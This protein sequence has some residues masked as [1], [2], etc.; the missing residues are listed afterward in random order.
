MIYRPEIDGL[1]ALAVIPVILFHAGFQI[2]S[3]GFIGVDVFF[4]ISGYLITTILIDDIEHNRFSFKTF[5]LRRARRLLPALTL[6]MI[7]CIPVAMALM[8]PRQLDQFA[9]GLIAVGI[10]ASNILIWQES[11]YFDTASEEKPLL[12]TWSLGIEEQYYILF[13]IFLFLFWRFGKNR[14]FWLIVIMAAFS[15]MLSEW[16]A[17]YKPSA[18]FYLLPTRAWELFAGSMTAIVA[19]DRKFQRNDYLSIIGLI[20]IIL[21][22]FIYDSQDLLPGLLTLVPVA[23][24]ILVIL[25]S[26]EGTYVAKFLSIKPL[27]FIGL[28]S[29]SAYL[30]HQPLFAFSRLGTYLPLSHLQII[31]LIFITFILAYLSYKFVETPF[32]RG[33]I[34]LKFTIIPLFVVLCAAAVPHGVY[35]DWLYSKEQVN[36]FES[37]TQ[38]TPDQN[39]CHLNS[40]IISQED[41]IFGESSASPNVAVIGDSHA[42]TFAYVLGES[43]QKQNKSLLFN[44]Y[45]HCPPILGVSHLGY[46]SNCNG[47]YEQAINKAINNEELDTI[48]LVARW[49][50]YYHGTYFKNPELGQEK[51]ADPRVGGVNETEVQRKDNYLKKL[52]ETMAAM[53]DNGKKVIFVK[54]VP[55]VGV[56]VPNYY[57]KKKYIYGNSDEMS[58]RAEFVEER[59]QFLDSLILSNIENEKFSLIDPTTV[60]CDEKSCMTELNGKPIYYDTNHLNL[61]GMRY[62]VT[63]IIGDIE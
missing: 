19:K 10:F 16:G 20:A 37:A 8:T 54:A 61:L 28:I 41:C 12:H 18:N 7:L 45:A 9:N 21:P 4:V 29:Y 38:K 31:S 43:F 6:V 11:G 23:G 15:L 14:V 32:R 30:I 47:Y 27:V 33:R 59:S 26:K 56:D 49:P 13:P 53:M 22:Y 46:Q 2:F 58:V 51:G 34:S 52:S 42:R 17:R 24:V 5:Y 40:D 35:Q 36:F 63:S 57:W 50:I 3:G 48:I 55:E 1:R 60:F 25:F 44:G 62:L 39:N